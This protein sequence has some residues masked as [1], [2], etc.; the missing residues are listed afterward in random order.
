MKHSKLL[1]MAV[2]ALAP[3]FGMAQRLALHDYLNA[4]ENAPAT[5]ESIVSA[6]SGAKPAAEKPLL[7]RWLDLDTLSNSE[8][9]RNAYAVGGFH[10]FDNAQQRSLIVGKVKLDAEGRYDIG[11]RASSGRYFNW[12]Y[13]SYTGENFSQ[14]ANNPHFLPSF[15]TPAE[16]FAAVQAIFSDPV[17][18]AVTQKL[19]SNGFQFYLRELYVRATPVNPVTI[20]FGSFGIE[21]GLST[22]ITTFD[23]DGYLS[24]ERVRLHDSRHLFFDEIGFTNAYFGDIATPNLFDRGSSL[25]K[26]NYRQ[27]FLKKQLNPRVGFSGEST[28]Q[29]GTETLRE[30]AVVGTKE[31]RIVDSVRFESYER[32]N[33]VSFPGAAHSPVGPI[34]ALA[35]PG[36]SGFAVA[37]Q[38]KLGRL[39]G[40]VGYASID[41]HYAVYSNHRF[42]TAV[43]FPLNGDAYGLGNRIYTHASY[44][45]APGVTA[46]GFYTHEVLSERVLT[47]NQQGLSAGM[48]FDLKAL[49]N[50]EKRIF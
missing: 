44:T 38:K 33:T 6:A 39:S 2:L 43:G 34:P 19:E 48:T 37:A 18:L 11:F 29:T 14:R 21:R 40:D 25:E 26:F 24:G 30:A 12:A 45:V 36:A 8:R 23:E 35:V 47:L 46:F 16:N 41:K 9:Y 7:G 3:H 22:E 31:S 27:V 1:Y 4:S 50:E 15:F 28:W 49:V 42:P 20:E 10:L 13:S 5:S 32:L 17:G